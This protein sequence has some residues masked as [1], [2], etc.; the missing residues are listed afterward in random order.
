MSEDQKDRI[1]VGVDGSEPSK[2]ALR[3]ASFLALSAGLSID[4]VS[5]WHI[6]WTSAEGWP[7]NLDPEQETAQMLDKAIRDVLGAEPAVPVRQRVHRGS[8]AAVLLDA[9]RNARLL[10]VGSRGHGGFSGLLLGSVSMACAE[11]APC[12]ILI[13]HGDDP[14]PA[15]GAAPKLQNVAERTD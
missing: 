6:P 8:A 4:V 12:P 13:V 1:V 5:A 11:H 3:W 9:S 7:A 10:T 2:Q 14:P 15:A